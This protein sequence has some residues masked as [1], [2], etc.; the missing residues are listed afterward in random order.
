MFVINPIVKKD[1]LL[2]T[3]TGPGVDRARERGDRRM[4]EAAKLARRWSQL[5]ARL[6]KEGPRPGAEGAGSV[7]R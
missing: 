7:A 1:K 4:A 6:W 2:P 3:L 5:G